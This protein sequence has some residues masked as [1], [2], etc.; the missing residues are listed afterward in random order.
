MSKINPE[1]LNFVQIAKSENICYHV[2]PKSN[3]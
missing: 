1:S 2:K 3:E